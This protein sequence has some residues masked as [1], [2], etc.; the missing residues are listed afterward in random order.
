MKLRG[1]LLRIEG[2]RREF[3]REE[4]RPTGA[5]GMIQRTPRGGGADGCAKHGKAAGRKATARSKR[6]LARL[7]FHPQ[8]PLR[9]KELKRSARYRRL[10]GASDR[11]PG[12]YR[13]PACG[14]ARGCVAFYWRFNC[15]APLLVF[16]PHVI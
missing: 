2:E 1:I 4:D 13:G 12:Y 9:R 16:A 15:V 5:G 8:C 10:P 3:K 11:G 7:V 14:V 6:C